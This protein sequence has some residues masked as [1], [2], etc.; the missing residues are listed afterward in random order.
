MA[1]SK[2]YLLTQHLN[3]VECPWCAGNIAICEHSPE[4]LVSQLQNTQSII[5]DMRKRET[6]AME[7]I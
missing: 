5:E 6:F 2:K 4:R 1:L 7:A 3:G